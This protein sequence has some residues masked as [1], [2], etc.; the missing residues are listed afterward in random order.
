MLFCLLFG[1][2][3]F[4]RCDTEVFLEDGREVGLV[5]ETY[6]VG[7]LCDVDFLLADESGSLFQSQI[8]D[9]LTGRDARH[10]LH[11]TM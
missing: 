10:L 9:E 8:A 5:V 7:Y 11:L 2:C 1:F 6:R 3:I 4:C